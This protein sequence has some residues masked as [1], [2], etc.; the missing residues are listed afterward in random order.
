MLYF[1]NFRWKI[2]G[3]NG[4]F[5]RATIF[6]IIILMD[7]NRTEESRKEWSTA[8]NVGVWGE[9][10]KYF[11]ALAPMEGVTDV[12]F[13]QVVARAGRPDLFF[14]EFTNVSSF[15]SE[16]GRDNAL[17]RLEVVQTDLP[18]VA[19]IWGKN[20]THFAE[21]AG[22]LEGL[23][24]AGLDINMGCP[25]RHVNAAG[26]GAAMIRT[27]ELA[28]DCLRQARMATRLPVSVKT[29]LGYSFVDEYRTWLPTILKEQ[30]A[31]LTVHLR[32]RKEMS[33]VPAHFELIPDIIGLKKAFSPETKLVVNGDIKNLE[34]AKRLAK[35]YPEVDGFMI[36]RGVFE[37]PFCFTEHTATR[38]EL[39]DLLQYHLD[40][41]DEKDAE[42]KLRRA[43][44]LG[45]GEDVE[46][47]GLAFEPL[48]R[49]FKI[50]LHSFPG[51]VELRTRLMECR[52][53]AEVRKIL[54][55]A[56]DREG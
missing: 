35:R 50:Y 38:G 52:N 17:E 37:N 20:P 42:I 32:T 34:Q 30:P 6:E 16:K 54:K 53:T 47:R 33:K 41:Y 21:L 24:F 51:A 45:E 12:I 23:G 8:V 46:V 22:A 4:R 18:I 29:R 44:K 1:G 2:T 56:R 13:R 14:T 9:L 5:D 11:T 7:E 10:P 40:L 25:D 31:A 36:G 43:L 15:A 39:M 3:V 49:F 55:E 26:G 48:K 19:Q 27:P 28:V